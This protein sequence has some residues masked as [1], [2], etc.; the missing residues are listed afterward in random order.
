VTQEGPYF[1]HRFGIFVAME[2]FELV[3]LFALLRQAIVAPARRGGLFAGVGHPVKRRLR[4]PAAHGEIHRAVLG[5]DDDI[6]QR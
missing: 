3:S 4:L 6:S 2:A 1:F 5:I